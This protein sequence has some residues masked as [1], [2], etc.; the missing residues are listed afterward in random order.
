[1]FVVKTGAVSVAPLQRC[2]VGDAAGWSSDTWRLG[3]E[4]TQTAQLQLGVLRQFTAVGKK[5][6]SG[7]GAWAVCLSHFKLVLKFSL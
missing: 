1:M 5:R 2:I 6:Y 4:T 3:G 7:V